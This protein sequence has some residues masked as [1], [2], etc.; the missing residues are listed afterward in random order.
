MTDDRSPVD[1][2]ADRFWEGVLELNPTTA[3]FYGDP[4]Y[5][6]QLEDPSPEGRARTRELMERT[7]REAQAIPIDDLPTE[8]RITRDMLEVI[9]ALQIEEDDQGL[10][11]LRVARFVEAG[12][13]HQVGEDHRRH[14]ALASGV[15]RLGLERTVAS[16]DRRATAGAEARVS[17]EAG[18]TAPTRHLDGRAADRAEP[19]AGLERPA[20]GAAG[21]RRRV[22]PGIASP[23]ARGLK[24][25]TTDRGYFT[26][27]Q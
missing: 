17:G 20:T 3:T 8:E 1:A 19:G 4:R 22:A 9:G 23:Q 10:H 27:C 7:V 14:L 16:G 13:A 5:A 21:H 24:R 11:Q 12:E 25:T 2:L 6:D 18:A 15:R 26:A